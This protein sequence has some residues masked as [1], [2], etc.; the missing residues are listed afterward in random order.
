MQCCRKA[1]KLSKTGWLAGKRACLTATTTSLIQQEATTP[2]SRLVAA[3]LLGNFKE[4]VDGI[5]KP[6]NNKNVTLSSL[7]DA[8]D[9]QE[10]EDAGADMR[11]LDTDSRTGVDGGDEA[12]GPLAV[13]LVGFLSE[14]VDAFRK[15]MLDMEADMVKII[16]CTR[17]QL[18][19]SLQQALESEY[20]VYEQPPLGTRRT[21]FLSG[22]FG[23]EVVDVIGGY[24]ESGLPQAVWAAAVPN[25]Y[26]RLVSELVS[27]V[28]ADNAAMVRRAQEAQVQRKAQDVQE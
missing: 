7:A 14:E 13:L 9:S 3:R 26:K 19:S 10:Q 6:N 22:M 20:P 24:R 18:G 8:G 17:A 4:W 27:E 11:R 2:G 12:F 25:N 15:L 23:A 5:G 1:C 21:V 16:P 28:H